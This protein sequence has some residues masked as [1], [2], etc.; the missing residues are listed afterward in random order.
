MQLRNFSEKHCLQNDTLVN[1]VPNLLRS[2]TMME[3]FA[4]SAAGA[5]A[6]GRG[7]IGYLAGLLSRHPGDGGAAYLCHKFLRA[8]MGMFR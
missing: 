4:N 3:F 2:R 8:Q 5:G 7:A 6:H 1:T